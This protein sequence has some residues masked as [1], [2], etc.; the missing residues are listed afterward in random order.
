MA[1]K[2]LFRING[3]E[4][5]GA[6]RQNLTL[7]IAD[8]CH[9]RV[10]PAVHFFLE[11]S[12]RKWLAKRNRPEIL[13][14][15]GPGKGQHVAKLVYLAHGFVEDSSDDTAVSMAGRPSVFAREFEMAN[16]PAGLFVQCEFQPH[17]LG[18][19]V[20]A[21]KAMILAW[22]G[23]AVDCVAVGDFAFRHECE[24]TILAFGIGSAT[25]LLTG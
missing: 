16:C 4:R 11:T 25:M 18:I 13:D 2:H 9:V 17:A 22:L 7:G 20:S 1:C 21:A 8:F 23:F 12:H 3:D 10:P 19:V 24:A 6:A 5:P 14:L 15:H